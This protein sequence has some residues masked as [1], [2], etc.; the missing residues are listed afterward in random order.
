M[1]TTSYKRSVEESLMVFVESEEMN[2][3]AWGQELFGSTISSL[4]PGLKNKSLT[5][6]S[7]GKPYIAYRLSGFLIAFQ[8]WI[9]ETIPVLEGK[10]CTIVGDYC[11]RILNWTSRVQEN[12]SAKLNIAKDIFG[13]PNLQV[14]ALTPT[15]NERQKAYSSGEFEH[16]ADARVEDSDDDFVAPCQTITKSK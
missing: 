12:V 15:I 7:D 3:Y 14:I 4:R 6:E 11:P 5:I 1:F 2:T 16:V 9:Y 8:I 13:H 10:I